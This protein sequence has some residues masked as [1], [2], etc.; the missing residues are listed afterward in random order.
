M[1][2]LTNNPPSKK[3]ITLLAITWPLFIEAFLQ[4]FMRIADIFMLSFV[5]DEA[6]AAIGVVNQIMMFTFVL[7]NF[8][9]M[10]SGVVI[11][12]FVGAKKPKEVS[13]TITNAM[14][15]NLAFGLFISG[16]IVIFREPFLILF[17]LEDHLIE[18]AN[19]YLLIV[20]GTLFTQAM[21]MTMSS[22]LQAQGYTKDV[23]YLVLGMNILNIIGNYLFIFGALGFPQLGVMGVAIATAVSRGIAMIV[24][25]IILY[26]RIEIKIKLKDY[27][28]LKKEYIK[29]IMGIGVPAA[30]EHLSHSLSQLIITV[31]IT[32]LGANALATRVY[33]Q[34]L[35]NFMTVF[36]VSVAKGMQIM[37]GQLVGAGKIEE[38]YR[39]MFKGLR[40]S[41]VIALSI[42]TIIAFFSESLLGIF[43]DDAE[44]IALGSILLFLGV[45]LEPGRT[46][47]L[48]IISSLRAA[49]DARFPVVV[50]IISMWG[51]SVT[52]AYIFGISLGFG[53]IGIWIAI[54]LDEWLRGILMFFRWR[55]RKWE[56]KILVEDEK[57]VISS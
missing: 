26:K 11:A 50:G 35:M 5:S 16:L 17:N 27:F 10:G 12:Q 33:T 47:N 13:I 37:I 29:K 30:G 24:V 56:Q 38:A 44:I 40:V 1:S 54:I 28:H 7:F 8:T 55:S 34:N 31:F 39:Q 9:A 22:A 20:G 51:V 18:Y 49:G 23:M 43:T 21:V 25:C 36:S 3:K 53:L 45:I 52:L 19:I 4:T 48:V 57:E 2:H 42:G 15:L 14:V 41:I 6:V 46:F 32:L